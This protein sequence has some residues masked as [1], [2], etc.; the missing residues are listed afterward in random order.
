M[1]AIESL[2]RIDDLAVSFGTRLSWQ[3][4]VARH[5]QLA[6][7]PCVERPCVKP[8]H[9]GPEAAL[10]WRYP[11]VGLP[12]GAPD[13]RVGSGTSRTTRR[14]KVEVART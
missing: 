8:Q 13:C 4:Q 7:T 10:P 6:S 12:G 9:H 2:Q 1:K 5:L 14:Q 11:I 3:R